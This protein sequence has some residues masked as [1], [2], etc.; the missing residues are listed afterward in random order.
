MPILDG[1]DGTLRSREVVVSYHDMFEE[2]PPCRDPRKSIADTTRPHQD[3][4]HPKNFMAQMLT[5]ASYSLRNLAI[6]A[7]SCD[8]CWVDRQRRRSHHRIGQCRRDR[9]HTLCA[10]SVWMISPR[11]PAIKVSL[12]I[13]FIA[14]MT[15]VSYRGIVISERLRA[16]LVSFQLVVLIVMSVIALVRVYNRSAGPQAVH[17]EWSC[18]RDTGSGGL[19][20]YCHSALHLCDRRG[21]HR[22]F[23]GLP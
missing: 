21:R 22:G 19:D 17:P 12:G 16:V 18:R 1:R 11:T 13:V 6:A 4:P 20:Q 9:C 8:G 2:F 15:Y 14:I 23:R 5:L 10:F 7:R 3:N